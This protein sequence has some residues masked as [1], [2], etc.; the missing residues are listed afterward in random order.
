[1]NRS[2]PLA[3]CTAVREAGS[4]ER[5]ELARFAAAQHG[6]IVGLLVLHTG[7]PGVAQELAQDAMAR[8]VE[9]WPKVQ[10][11]DNPQAWLTRV[12]LNL[13]A[14]RYRRR[15]AERRALAR[16]PAAAQ[17]TT[18]PDPAVAIA[19]RQALAVLTRRQRTV[20]ILRFYEDS[21]CATQ[22]SSW[23]APREP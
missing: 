2:G 8:L 22:R 1:M 5:A 19:T 23:T 17:S 10:R 4:S 14:S 11:M 18:P 13:A 6:R 3:R 16:M 20:L 15:A 7:D 9:H 21:A 12:A